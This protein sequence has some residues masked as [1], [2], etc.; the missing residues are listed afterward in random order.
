[1]PGRLATRRDINQEKSRR[2]EKF[3]ID[4]EDGASRPERVR[5]SNFFGLHLERAGA[6]F[7]SVHTMDRERKLLHQQVFSFRRQKRFFKQE[8]APPFALKLPGR[9][10]LN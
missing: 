3:D 8:A 7:K 10:S 9:R 4:S 2:F 5:S 6:A 1:V